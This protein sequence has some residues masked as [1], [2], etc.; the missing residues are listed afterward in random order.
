MKTQDFIKEGYIADDAD[1]MHKDH[2]V[3]MARQDCYNAAKNAIELHGLL[4][5]VSEMEGLEGWVSEKITLAADYLKTVKEYLEYNMMSQVE[6][7]PTFSMESAEQKYSELL[8][9]AVLGGTKQGGPTNAAEYKRMLG[10]VYDLMSQ[11]KDPANRDIYNQKIADL[12][13]VAK[14]RGIPVN[15]DA[16]VGG[17]SAGAI[18]T[19]SAPLGGKP[20]TGKPKKVGNMIRRP[21]VS[22]GK[23]VY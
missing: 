17:V 10:D 9:E 8:G 4:K 16:S 7:A 12:K 13:R 15:E 14:E 21:K 6:S 19:V 3:Q 20:G 11:D 1:A 2:E 5:N 23:G 18:A 22:V